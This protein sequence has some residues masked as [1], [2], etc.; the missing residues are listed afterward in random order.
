MLKQSPGALVLVH[1][2]VCGV[3]W[4]NHVLKGGKTKQTN[5]KK[6]INA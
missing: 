6:A 5:K 4:V 1:E 3:N 2:K